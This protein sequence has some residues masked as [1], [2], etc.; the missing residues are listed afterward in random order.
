MQIFGPFRVAASQATQGSQR[1][2]DA[3]PNPG[4]PA[5]EPNR[6]AG[7]VDELDLS[8]AAGATRGSGENSAIAGGGEIRLERVAS[9]RR[10]IADGNYE[11]PE[12]LDIALNRMLDDFA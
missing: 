7:P 5:S 12:K 4:T 6:A 1:I 2:N 10:A 3:K 11:T 9:L 8:H